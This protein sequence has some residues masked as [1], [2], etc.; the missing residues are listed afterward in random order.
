MPRVSFG[1][2]R[3]LLHYTSQ[4]TLGEAAELPAVEA[5]ELVQLPDGNIAEYV[6]LAD[7]S[8][9]EFANEADARSHREALRL[10]KPEED[11]RIVQSIELS[12][13]EQD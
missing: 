3:V 9:A 2:V 1:V 6:L 7:G 13:A 4:L 5:G 12:L 10:Q 8:P 11:F